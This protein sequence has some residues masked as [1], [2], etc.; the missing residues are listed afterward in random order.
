MTPREQFKL[1]YH[2][3]RVGNRA[4]AAMASSRVCRVIAS[5]AAL[6]WLDSQS[7]YNAPLNVRLI[8][9]KHAKSSIAR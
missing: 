1:A 4:Q 8:T 3:C 7:N 6:A 2:L 5:R 9:Y